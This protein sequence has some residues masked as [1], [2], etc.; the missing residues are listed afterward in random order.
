V[1]TKAGGPP[2]SAVKEI[3]ATLGDNVALDGSG[4]VWVWGDN[5]HGELAVGSVCAP[6]FTTAGGTNACVGSTL[7]VRVA[8]LHPA[9]H[10]GAGGYF[11]FAV[12]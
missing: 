3:A 7:P 10:I 5:A 1:L 8:S 11:A 12:N 2:L 9:H 4:T 6:S